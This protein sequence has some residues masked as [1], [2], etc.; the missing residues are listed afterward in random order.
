MTRLPVRWNAGADRN[1]LYQWCPKQLSLVFLMTT[2]P[3]HPTVLIVGAKSDPFCRLCHE[4]MLTA[5]ARIF[6]LDT[7][8]NPRFECNLDLGEHERSAFVVV[9]NVPVYLN[10]L[11]GLLLRS[12]WFAQDGNTPSDAADFVAAE[13][14]AALRFLAHRAPCRVINRLNFRFWSEPTIDGNILS[15]MLPEL[16]IPARRVL[17]CAGSVDPARVQAAF[18]PDPLAYRPFNALQ[19]QLFIQSPTDVASLRVL[20]KV[21][22]A[23]L[24]SQAIAACHS[25]YVVGPHFFC[26]ANL[27][28]T[29]VKARIGNLSVNMCRSLNVAFAKVRWIIGP[30][31]ACYCHDLQTFPFFEPGDDDIVYPVAQALSNYLLS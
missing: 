10:A 19:P 27:H 20:L 9:D 23:R 24:E 12:C 13:K 7:D 17:L 8:E 25:V 21:L 28:G 15:R 29:E 6:F 1:P 22:P 16:S 14:T 30:T 5:K 2:Q 11:N 26:A 3:Y 18:A 31:G 4:K